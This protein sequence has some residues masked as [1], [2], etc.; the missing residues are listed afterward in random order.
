MTKTDHYHHGAL[1]EALLDSAMRAIE[2]D[3]LERLSLRDLAGTIGV[4]KTAPY[5]HFASKRALLEAIAAEGFRLLAADLERSE[6]PGP[7]TADRLGTIARSYIDFARSR[8]ALYRLMFSKL[9]YSL[10]SEACR[11][12][13][14]R[15][16][17]V[18]VRAVDA[19][20]STGW[21]SVENQEA[22]ILSVWALVHGWAGLLI[23][24]LLP[25]QIPAA[26]ERWAEMVQ[27]FLS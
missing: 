1:R 26:E 22:V 6:E 7:G 16:F 2:S 11:L 5:R 13:S 14:G 8:P 18:L 25:R 4:S 12:N 3:G 17:G 10:E 21:R 20:M 19:R 15:A 9:G 27:A 24:G 23:D